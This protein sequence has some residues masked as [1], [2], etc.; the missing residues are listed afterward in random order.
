MK[1]K[2]STCKK[3]CISPAAHRSQTENAAD[4]TGKPSSGAIKDSLSH[5]ERLFP[6]MQK[7]T[8]N[9]AKGILSEKEKPHSI[10]HKSGTWIYAADMLRF[11]FA[12]VFHAIS[13]LRILFSK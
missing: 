3:S 6:A 9:D 7:D 1:Q 5:C 12:H 11:I 13:I 4:N 2:T 10:A 8:F